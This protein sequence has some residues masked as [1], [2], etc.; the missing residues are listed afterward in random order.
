MSIQTLSFHELLNHHFIIPP[1]QRGYRWDNNQVTDLLNDLKE[2][3]ESTRKGRN[4]A[5]YCLQPIVV[6]PNG[7][8]CFTVIDGQQRLTTIYL[9]LNYLKQFRLANYTIFK[10]E[11]TARPQQQAFLDAATYADDANQNAKN[12]IDT[13]YMSA[14]YRTIES[15]FN[16][17]EN[18]FFRFDI[19]RIFIDPTITNNARIIWYEIANQS[20]PKAFR[21]LNYGKI[22]LT[23]TELVKAL[24]LQGGQ[25]ANTAPY[26]RAIE[27]DN[28]EH[29][30]NNPSLWGMLA[31]NSSAT[32]SH[33]ELVIDFVADELNTSMKTS[34]E[35]GKFQEPFKRKSEAM[36]KSES[37]PRDYF[38]YHVVN[39]YINRKVKSNKKREEVLEDIWTRIRNTFNLITNWF[40]NRNWFHYIGLI[41]ILQ[42][43]K[44]KKSRREF[45]SEIHQMA[46]TDS[47]PKQQTEFTESLRKKIGNMIRLDDKL[48]LTSLRY[49][50]NNREIIKILEA[51]NVYEALQ[52]RDSSS[53]FA[54]SEFED[55]N[56]TS[57]EHIH[58][59]NITTDQNFDDFTKWFNNR[60]EAKN[61]FT[62][63]D[64]RAIAT[65]GK[66]EE[67]SPEKQAELITELK[68]KIEN[69]EI[70]IR[71]LI[72]DNKI[73]QQSKDAL[74]TKVAVF[75]Q[76]FGDLS[77]ISEDQ[78][79]SISNMALVDK[80]TNSA[81]QNFFLDRKRGILSERHN[82][83]DDNTGKAQTYVPIATF[84][85]FAKEWTQSQPGDMRLWRKTDR[86][87][88]FKAIE[89]AY[90]YFTKIQKK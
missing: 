50:D 45:V 76:I 15:W 89:K 68:S 28:M 36:L 83:V 71:K 31:E 13:F 11:L 3:I 5:F 17:P 23:S 1:Y 39:E 47:G 32:G 87:A 41:R 60:I 74:T 14:A 59:Q 66:A 19:L 2:F 82:N 88:Y 30:L 78:L 79:H 75:D 62:N 56:V 10:L 49:K 27:W 7:G 25:I 58:P 22:P 67:L 43:P 42:D 12:N 40:D 34:D 86:E 26:R 52:S 61:N 37:E 90:N 81:L 51:L 21:R 29:T 48:T 54:F 84:K 9:L 53:R 35:N 55:Y 4:D 85:A 24:I 80:D 33:L 20:A 8:N 64:W 70:E 77:G 63:D 57:L 46:Y 6:V 44:N 69:I 38:N 65:S 18:Q 73:Y 72:P 16:M